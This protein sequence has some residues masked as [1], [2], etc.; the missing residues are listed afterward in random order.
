MKQLIQS[1][2]TG[3]LGL[4]DVPAPF[5]ADQGIVIRTSLSLV[6][7]GTEK[8]IVDL[9]RKSLLGKAQARPDLV[10]QV[11]HKMKQEGILTTLEKVFNKLDTP[12]PLGY[13]CVGKVVEIGNKL[14]G[15]RVGERVACGGSGYANHSEFNY[16]P[17]NLFV[18]V[19]EAVTDEEAC[20]VTL[21]AIAMQGIRQ[22]ELT[23][24]DRVVVIG[25]GLIGQLTIQLAKANGCQVMGVDLD[26]E[27]L[28]IARSIAQVDVCLA[29]QV[30]LE[31]ERFSGG[32]GVDAVIITAA[33]SSD[34][35]IADA[36]S[37]CRQKG[38]IVVVGMVGMDLPRTDFY[39]KELEL[40]LSMAYGPG[41]YDPVYEQQGIDYPFAYVRWT[42]Q[43]NFESFLELVAEKKI[44][45]QPLISHRFQFE[46][47]LEAYRL[48]EG[49]MNESYL[50]I[51]LHYDNQNSYE[52]TPISLKLGL[53][54]PGKIKLG[55]IGAGNFTRS[56]LLP[57]LKKHEH[58]AL[59]ALCSATGVTA[60]SVGTKHGFDWITTHVDDMVENQELDAV[61][62]TTRHGNHGQLVNKA[63]ENH[64][65]V[66]V[67]KP[68][69]IFRDELESLDELIRNLE[70]IPILQVGYNRRYS[71][72]LRKMKELTSDRT[73]VIHYRINAGKV[74][75]DSWIQDPMEGGGRILGELCH[76]V[77]TVLYLAGSRIQTVYAQCVQNTEYNLPPEDNVSV[78]LGFANGSMATIHYMAYGNPLMPKESIELFSNQLAIHLNNFR[79]L[80]I[81]SQDKIKRIH[82]KNQEKGFKEELDAFAKAIQ[83]GKP[84]VTFEDLYQVSKTCFLVLES[85]KKGVTIKI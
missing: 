58:Y 28:E 82:Q 8:M 76:F 67:E 71:P 66:F 83:T 54:K 34:Q 14:K 9:A 25:L 79:E 61:F 1:F 2:K 53:P 56:I 40:K 4:F 19:P 39:K 27:K 6:S 63:L 42:E 52:K 38:R 31:A 33:T 49:E 13:S 32:R 20:F 41:R 16:I 18:K 64:K 5:C 57:L 21:G 51:L 22:A 37:I 80:T 78:I 60:H 24:G 68:L 10:R 35:P 46:N 12:I 23:L 3:E 81:Y 70:T 59:T 15:V 50:G 55:L 47:A 77:D 26:P 17:Q 65:A 74:P 72:M 36:G 45:L 73:M 11:I 30:V 69:T 44:L 29:S 48:L 75:M 84:A 43:R 85:L 62:I 7:T